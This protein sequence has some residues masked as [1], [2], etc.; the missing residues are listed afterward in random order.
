MGKH[1]EG[2]GVRRWRLKM[3]IRWQN[4]MVMCFDYD[5]QQIP[6]LQGRYEE[7]RRKVLAASDRDTIFRTGIWNTAAYDIPRNRW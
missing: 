1:N 4:D 6:E 2:K 3:A 7:M 5:G